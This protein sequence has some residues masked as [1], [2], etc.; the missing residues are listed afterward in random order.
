MILRFP[1]DFHQRYIDGISIH[2]TFTKID[3]EPT[4]KLIQ[5]YVLD[6]ERKEVI[7]KIL[8]S[9]PSTD[10]YY[11]V[12]YRVTDYYVIRWLRALGSK[13]E[14]LLPWDLRQEMTREIQ[15]MFNLYGH[16]F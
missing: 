8:Q 5:Q 2:D 3:Y 14:V 9:R 4:F 1:E 7:L 13:V 12:N 16:I 10:A 11:R 6:R 15:Y